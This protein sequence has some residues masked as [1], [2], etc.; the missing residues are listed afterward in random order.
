MHVQYLELCMK[1]DNA[2][3]PLSFQLSLLTIRIIILQLLIIIC[4]Y[5]YSHFVTKKMITVADFF[6][7]VNEWYMLNSKAGAFTFY[8]HFLSYSAILCP[9]GRHGHKKNVSLTLTFTRCGLLS[10]FPGAVCHTEGLIQKPRL[11]VFMAQRAIQ[12]SP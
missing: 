12:R 2:F 7:L 9:M 1:V 3:L 4:R 11:T 8:D 5:Y 10:V 6:G